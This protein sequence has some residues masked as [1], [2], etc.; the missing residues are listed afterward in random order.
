MAQPTTTTI[1]PNN[2]SDITVSS[3]ARH[4]SQ[5]TTEV[6]DGRLRSSS[7]C[8]G[9]VIL[10]GA[11]SDPFP[12][13]RTVIA[14]INPTPRRAHRGQENPATPALGAAQPLPAL[15]LDV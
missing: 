9:T 6:Y 3:L 11:V 1:K 14:S 10:S 4:N 8:D 12:G 15:V 13:E 5:S 2:T 7:E